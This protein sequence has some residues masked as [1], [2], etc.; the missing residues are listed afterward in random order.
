SEKLEI[1][2]CPA[3]GSASTTSWLSSTESAENTSSSTIGPAGEFSTPTQ[4]WS[5]S[6]LRLKTTVRSSG[7]STDS[8]LPSNDAGP[9]GSSIAIW[10][11]KENFT[12]EEVSSLPLAKVRPSLSFTVNSPGEVN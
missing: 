4:V 10:R 5:F 11:S 1:V 3:N 2:Y 12:S 8:K 9:F 7:V 6:C